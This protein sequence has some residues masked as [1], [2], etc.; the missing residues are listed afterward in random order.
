M[1]R[2]IIIIFLSSLLQTL[3]G[4]RRPCVDH[5][6]SYEVFSL[7]YDTSSIQ[8]EDENGDGEGEGDGDGDGHFWSSE[9]QLGGDFWSPEGQLRAQIC[10]TKAL[11]IR[12]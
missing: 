11:D 6:R 2:R 5:A 12:F 1:G 7:P 8:L 9:G 10:I 3:R 4:T